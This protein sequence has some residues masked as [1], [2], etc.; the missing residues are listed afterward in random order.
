MPVKWHSYMEESRKII[1]ENAETA[2]HPHGKSDIQ[3]KSTDSGIYVIPRSL[4]FI[5]CLTYSQ[6]T[7]TLEKYDTGQKTGS[8]ALKD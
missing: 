5:P 6:R 4:F 7:D 2:S 1:C 3:K 8:S